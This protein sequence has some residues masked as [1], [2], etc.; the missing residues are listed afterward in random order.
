MNRHNPL[1][2]VYHWVQPN[3][4]VVLK[5]KQHLVWFLAI[6]IGANVG[7]LAI[8][9]RTGVSLVQYP[10]LGTYSEKVATAAGNLPFWVII[11]VPGFGGLLVG[12]YLH[13]IQPG[14]RP[15]SIADVIEARACG[16]G[17][18]KFWPGLSS[19]LVHIVSLGAGASGGREGP[20]VHLGATIGS[21]LTRQFGLPD[22]AC[23]VLLACGAASAVSASFNAP[24]AG[25]LFAHEVILAHYGFSAFVPIVLSSTVAA[26]ISRQWF[27]D[28]AAFIIP[29]YHIAS[30]W[31]FP[32]FALL[33][34]TCA[35]VAI[36]FQFAMIGTDWTARKITMPL[37][38]RPVV[39]GLMLGCIAVFYPEIL[40]VG[41]EATDKALRHEF[42]LSV[43]ISLIIAKTAATAITMASR[44]GGGIIAP[45]LFLGAMAGGAFGIVAAMINPDMASSHG[46][47]AILGMA[48]VTAAVIGAPISTTL[49][50]FELT[51][52]YTLSIALLMTVAIATGLSMAINGK[53][54]FHWQL[55]TRGVFLKKG[56]HQHLV[57]S[58]FVHQFMRKIPGES[59][60]GENQPY[61]RGDDTLDTAL[62]LFNKSGETEIPVKAPGNDD[63]IIGQVHHVD[64]LSA[65][66]SA[67]IDTHEEEH[68]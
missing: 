2:L 48:A 1:S 65:F 43:L 22:A 49:V 52:G 61:L 19:A 63:R 33:G 13:W 38:T 17:G 28:T 4:S 50:V 7:L 54:Y 27:G 45:C 24:I 62:R 46:L 18:L 57:R 25:V 58:M 16:G 23:R 40:G 68:R 29:D 53:S 3:L 31:E 34:F 26:I 51:G 15:G 14:K 21:V 56:A 8:L 20:M 32:A 44:F 12:L 67:L 37:W 55:E 5:S 39:G 42:G 41:Y 6:I 64:A 30:L 66:N 11:A 35:I 60:L 47:Y 9:F 59:I 36:L 10:W